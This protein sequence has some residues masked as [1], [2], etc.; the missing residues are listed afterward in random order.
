METFTSGPVMVGEKTETEMDYMDSKV[1]TFRE[2]G[3]DAKW[4][5]TRNGAPII[6]ARVPGDA[7]KNW[8]VVDND[9]WL[10]MAKQGIRTAFDNHT[11]LGAFFS[12]RA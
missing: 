2:A 6:A 9:M 5:R 10:A 11:A 8:Y 7:D 12:I 4:T 3:L 1:G